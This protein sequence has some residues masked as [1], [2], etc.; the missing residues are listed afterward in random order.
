MLPI[1]KVEG[2]SKKFKTS[3]GLQDMHF[4]LYQGQICALIGRNGAGK[5]TLFK[6]IANQIFPTS[7]HIELFGENPEQNTHIRKR[8]GFMIEHSAWISNFTGEKNLTYFSI[9]RGLTNKENIHKVLTQV[10][11][12]GVNKKVKHYSL[13][14]KQRLNI[15][16]ALLSGPD[17]LVLDEPIN[18]LDAE[19]I[20]DFRKLMWKLNHEYDITILISSHILNELEQLAHRFVFIDNGKIVEDITKEEMLQKGKK[21][22]VIKASPVE[23]AIQVLEENIKD[24]HYKVLHDQS[25]WIDPTIIQKHQVNKLLLEHDVEIEEFKIQ[26][27]NL[28][29]YFL[30][31]GKVNSY[32]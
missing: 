29:D 26:A 1:I 12:K 11:L 2:L 14:M 20:K 22:L 27:T 13:G 28:E 3:Y 32:D 15:A 23:K 18:G 10:G 8:V 4:Q 16:L 7:G 31:K 6:L 25:L 19:G 24:I 21:Y 5:S 9:Q 17:L 30:N